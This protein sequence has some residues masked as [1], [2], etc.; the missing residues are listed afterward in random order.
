[1]A[2]PELLSLA[3]QGSLQSAALQVSVDQ[4]RELG[5]HAGPL[6]DVVLEFVTVFAFITVGHIDD[7]ISFV[8]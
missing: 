8:R 2:D 4:G 3:G 6:S 5:V 7:D 1:L